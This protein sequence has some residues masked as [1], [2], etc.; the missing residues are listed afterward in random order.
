MSVRT[1]L[2]GFA[3]LVLAVFGRGQ[4]LPPA[5]TQPA[6]PAAM[7]FSADDLDK[8]LKEAQTKRLT[9]EREQVAAEIREGLLFDPAKIDEAV[10][11]LSAGPKNT[12][13]DNAQRI[14]RAFALVDGRFAKAYELLDKG[15]FQ[16]AAGAFKP[17]ISERDTS[18]LAATKRFAYA[19]ALAGAA[20]NEDAAEAYV[21]LVAA[22]PD[23]FSFASLG[24]LKAGRTYEKLHR[25]YHAMSLYKLWIDSFGLLDSQTSQEL[26][27][28]VDKIAADYDRPLESLS[29]KMSDVQTRLAQ[30]DSGKDTQQKQRE[31][32]TMLDDLIATAEEQ[33]S[34][35]SQSQQQQGQKPQEGQ[36]QQPG[37]GQS[38][39]PG[40]IGQPTSPATVSKLVAGPVVR[41]SGLSE[42]R[43]SDPSDDWGKLPAVE[44][45]KLLESFK[46]TM[47]ERYREMIGDYYKKVG[48]GP[49]R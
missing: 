40:G 7:V 4:V 11:N 19:E 31:I 27:D 44:R 5:S 24:L 49:V 15:N 36:G 32:V 18:Y 28:R 41:P 47:P 23:R 17:L 42:V 39:P 20:R 3:I 1:I 13:D 10:R 2:G 9:M 37:Q 8:F 46:E 29:K 12:C 21:D 48:A 26:A 35:S 22:M 30:T 25:L 6:E 34:S 43:P 14:Y 45:Q 16:A 33:Q 38:G